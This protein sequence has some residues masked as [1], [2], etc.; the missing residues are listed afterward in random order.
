MHDVVVI[1][2]GPAGLMAA[3][4]LSE[5]GHDVVVLEEHSDVGYPV[6]CTGLL[7]LDA[8]DEF[9]LPRETILAVARSARFVAASGRA[10]AIETSRIEAAIV[11]RGPFDAA[12]ACRAREAG[13]EVR[14]ATRARHITIDRRCV[15]VEAGEAPQ[16]V[17]ARACV[18]ACGVQYRFHRLFGLGV[19]RAFVQSAQIETPFVDAADVEVRFGTDIAPKGFAW[20]VPFRRG[21]NP[22][23]RIG[24]IAASQVRQRFNRFVSAVCH[25][26][27]VQATRLSP[28][29]LRIMPLAP[30]SRT[31]GPRLVAI[32]DAAGL[33]KPTT[34]GGIYYS[35]LSARLAAETLDEA[36]RRDCLDQE[37]LRIY[38]VH[39][40]ESLGPELRA[41]LAFR[42]I[43]GKLDDRAVDALVKLAQLDGIV[44]LLIDTGRF[45]WHRDAALALLRNPSF[46]RIVLNAL[47]R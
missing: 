1:G 12:L 46:R 11:D 43:A 6:H 47:W 36:L 37:Q 19:P 39:W 15:R 45:N 7:G 29:R 32:G 16:A 34:G 10:V 13:A 35:L 38:E 44:Q 17:T 27:A 8:F 28:P 14:L 4:F 42:A 40:R 31:Y 26:A 21:S 30:I 23:A 9:D 3:R 24:L 5:A 18:L 41:G 33:V 25:D 20:V 2:A 22:Y